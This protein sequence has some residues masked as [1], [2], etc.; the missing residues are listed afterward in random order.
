MIQ[1]ELIEQ[2]PDLDWT[3][4]TLYEME[5]FGLNLIGQTTAMYQLGAAG[6]LG[7]V[8]RNLA[9]RPWLWLALTNQID[10]TTLKELRKECYRIPVGTMTA[11]QQG[12]SAAERFALFFGFVPTGDS[13]NMS[14]MAYNIYRRN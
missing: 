3:E 8:C 9:E 11:I 1:I 7:L 14:G 10:M 5:K 2:F 13:F 4:Y 12:Y 6:V